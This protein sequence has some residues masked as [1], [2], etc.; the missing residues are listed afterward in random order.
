LEVFGAI[1]EKQGGFDIVFL[2]QF[3]EKEFSKSELHRR[4]G[5]PLS[6]HRLQ[7]NLVVI[8]A[9]TC[10]FCHSSARDSLAS[11]FIIN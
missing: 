4:V 11:L 1:N 7:T 3:V 9:G 5:C 2:Q 10:D 6:L 8:P